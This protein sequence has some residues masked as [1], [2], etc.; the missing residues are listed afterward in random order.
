MNLLYKTQLTDAACGT[1]I[2]KKNIYNQLKITTNNFD[3]EFEVLCKFAKLG[4][5]IKEYL[6]DFSPRTFEEGKK[7]R[8]I[9]DGSMILKTIVKNF[10]N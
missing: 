1:K 2:F 8:A 7:L 6:V 9:K 10:I 4:L 5:L 3:F